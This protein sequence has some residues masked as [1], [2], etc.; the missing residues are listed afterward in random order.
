MADREA[1]FTLTLEGNEGNVGALFAAFVKQAKSSVSDLEKT[2][3]NLKLFGNLDA[4]LKKAAATVDQTR[5]ALASLQRA[6]QAVRET[7]E[8]LGKELAAGLTQA[9]RAAAA[10][11]KDFIKQSTAVD[12]L[13]T[14][15]KAAGVDVTNLAAAE[16][17]LAEATRQ[18]AAA[19]VEQQNK[20]ATGFR[21]LRDIAPE[22]NRITAAYNALA[23]SGKLSFG[24]LSTLHARA[25]QQITA[26]RNSVGGV[27]QA[28]RD[29]RGSVLAFGAAFAGIIAA[30]SQSAEN[31]RQFSTQIAAVGTIAG[32]SDAKLAELGNG[33]RKLSRDMGVD[34]VN[35]ARALYDI[36]GS[37]IAPDNA[38][39][40]LTEATK[41]ARAGLTDVTTAASVGVAVLNGYQL[42]VTSLG[43]VYDV[44]FQ[45]VKDGVVTFPEL[46]K[47]IGTVIPI[48]RAANVPL[49][50]LGA[51]FVVLTRQGIDAPEAATAIARA[52]QDLAAPAPE[53]AEKMRELGIS[54]DGLIGTVEQFANKNLSLDQITKLIPDI[55]ASRA[56]LALSQN[57]NLLRDSVASAANS[58][59]SMQ[60]AY[61]RMAA[62]PQAK[63]DRFNAS[64]KDLSLSVGEFVTSGSG[65][66]EFLTGVA[67]AFNAMGDKAKQ[68][69]ISIVALTAG[70]AAL[71][72]L[73]RVLAVP[74][75]LLAG[76]MA[77]LGTSGTLVASG[78]TAV[79]VAVT[80]LQAGISFLLGFKLGE[81]L[82]EWSAAVRILG[83]VLGLL[84]A[85]V[86]NFVRTS[87]RV[88]IAVLTGNVAALKEAY[89]QF[90]ANNQIIA[91]G[92]VNAVTGATEKSRSLTAAQ[93]QLG[94]ALNKT[95]KAAADSATAVDGAVTALL[96]KLDGQAKAV[97]AA[98][99][100]TQS[101]LTSLVASLTKGVQDITAG[102]QAAVQALAASVS[103]QLAGLSSFDTQKVRDTVAI[104]KQA[105]LERLVILQQFSVDALKA[106]DAEA[107]A[108]RK[109][110]EKSG[111][112][113][114]RVDQEIAQAR[115]GVLQSVVDGFRAHVNELLNL[116]KA[117]LENV[118]AIEEQRR[119]INQSVEEK[120]RDIRRQGLTEYQQYG[121]KVNEIDLF[122]SKSRKALAEGDTKLAE[123][124][125]QKAIA[126]AS[127]IAGAVKQDGVEVVSA[128]SAAETAIS[129]IK[130]A[131]DLLNKSLTVRADAER[132]G[133]QAA[134]DGLREALPLLEQYIAKQKE[135]VALAK[136]G[137]KL[138]IDADVSAVN[139][140]V[141]D[142][143]KQLQARA[144]TLALITD[145]KKANEDIKALKDDLAKG[146]PVPLIAK[147]EALDAAIKAVKDA[148]PELTLETTK[149]LGLV[150]DLRAKAEDLA[151]LRPEINA[152]VKSNVADVQA[153]IDNLKKPT[154]S[155]HTVH[156]KEVRDGGGGSG[157]AEAPAGVFA[158]GGFVGR[159]R[160]PSAALNRF[161]TGYQRFAR[162]GQVFR[163]PSWMKVPGTGSGDTVPAALQAGS[164]VV[165]KS[166]S[167]FY[168]DGIMSR[169]ARGVGRF[170]SGGVVTKDEVG[171]WAEKTF[172]FNPFAGSRDPFGVGGGS[173]DKKPVGFKT[174]DS[175]QGDVHPPISRDVRP[176]PDILLTAMNVIAYAKE[177]L[178]SVGI[179]NPLLGS[180]L[181]QL[182]AGIKA[183]DVNPNDK[184]ALES[185][186]L[187]A[188]TIGVNPFLFSMWGKTQATSGPASQFEAVAFLDWLA[189]RGAVGPDGQVL[190]KGISVDIG[191]FAERFF[192]SA[193]NPDF[194]NNFF[195]GNNPNK[196]V[197]RKFGSGGGTGDTVPALLTPGEWV[198][199][200]FAVSRFGSGLMQAINSMRVSPASLAGM[201]GAPRAPQRFATGG[202]VLPGG[203][204]FREGAFA[205]GNGPV[206]F[207]FPIDGSS[208][209]SDAVLERT[210][211]PFFERKLRKAGLL[212]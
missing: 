25:Q 144:I 24:E 93:E 197:N 23:S 149:A 97:E 73:L 185:L 203:G 165:R 127:S 207:N 209:L 164:F 152:T 211:G 70:L 153:Q 84:A 120:I 31:F 104:Q 137:I 82:Y 4:D 143:E 173:S 14:S 212:R 147:T 47:S 32:V 172:G 141:D 61:E 208:L 162:G 107:V 160:A 35:S 57:F 102:A 5:V 74:L 118:R 166:A 86:D 201:L 170:A 95:A 49:E 71:L 210:V 168:G 151:T 63:V 54:F 44:L 2:T 191:D 66:I 163:R 187:A 20:T 56:V 45:V 12:K 134:A 192:G 64:I 133:A 77:S 62:T 200:K 115:I 42:E 145:L 184:V 76:S 60:A 181:P 90:R 132:E 169:L 89:N 148:K 3:S 157:G 198:I 119:G 155:T 9:S 196:K 91:E 142:L 83:D 161:A 55:R 139:K 171:K 125:A 105:A 18:A 43:H 159:A 124:F 40:V 99:S 189:K 156:I 48:A 109:I 117:H 38:I 140:A 190:S 108:R 33:V 202:P 26:L 88:F 123:E 15:L 100:S 195:F 116:E 41:A 46:A 175:F 138:R 178:N 22:V 110:A 154:E 65:F 21:T 176:I 206:T 17:K 27:G 103:T 36:L 94:T 150:A 182:L 78:F 34:A 51:A 183:L 174:G 114:K 29:I 121:D 129:K 130:T 205:G 80:A 186:L 177:M 135:A 96:G 81:I 85:T 37:G 52:I 58:A 69:T 10:A 19:Q 131:Q 188:E 6:A 179:E 146:V 67:N 68:T 194:A 7:G 193:I 128:S 112:D 122:L 1:K 101:R 53:A 113:L 180:L 28:F 30:G 167:Q 72:A 126:A 39:A 111:E 92:Y 50:E 87:L 136:E 199:N 204:S 16:L 106:F 79:T 98:L 59:G 11:E 75:N 8:P 13:R 158:R